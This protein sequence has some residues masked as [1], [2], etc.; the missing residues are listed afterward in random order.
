MCFW[1]IFILQQSLDIKY[2]G[3]DVMMYMVLFYTGPLLIGNELYQDVGHGRLIIS[4][5]TDAYE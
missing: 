1:A 3:V 4:K 5:Y 2:I